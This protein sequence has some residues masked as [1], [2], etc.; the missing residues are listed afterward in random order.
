MLTSILDAVSG[1]NHSLADTVTVWIGSY[2]AAV[3]PLLFALVLVEIGIAPMFFLPGDPLLFLCGALS[4][5]EGG[6]N[7]W[8]LVLVFFA[9]T[10]LGSGMAYGVGRLLG[11]RAYE[12]NYRW[13]DRDALRRAHDFFEGRGS[14]GLLVTPYIAVL[15]TFAPL[16]AG[17]AGMGVGR[18]AA[19]VSG[20][21]VLW[22]A[23]LVTAGHFFG[24]VPFVRE[25]MGQ[26]VLAGI[27]LGLGGL[28]LRRWRA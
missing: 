12:R 1:L 14:W 21:A 28:A 5:G 15:R 11:R 4:V 27:A 17:V 6:L 20:G 9:A 22:S 3:Y 26:L 7:P 16:A 25:H 13:L 24:N 18:F 2:G 19:A 23:G 8:L 10:V